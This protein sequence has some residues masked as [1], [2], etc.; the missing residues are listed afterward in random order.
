V[1][2]KYNDPQQTLENI[3]GSILSQLIQEL[4]AIPTALSK[5]FEQHLKQNTSPSLQELIDVLT[6]VLKSFKRTYVIVD[7]LDECT[8]EM[9]WDLMEILRSEELGVQLLLTSRFLNNIE[10]ELKVAKRLEIKANKTDLELYIDRHVLRNRN[11]RKIVENSPSIREDV[12]SAVVA[13]AAD[14]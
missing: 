2:I 7:A 3:I 10:E 11:L 9:R 5:L 8:E 13:T 14:M 6:D 1:Y 4:E 12:K